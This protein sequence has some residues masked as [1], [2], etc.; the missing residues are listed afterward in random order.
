MLYNSLI[1]TYTGR[2]PA[3]QRRR[4]IDFIK[5]LSGQSNRFHFISKDNVPV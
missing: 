4:I 2:T 1:Y 3:G 5:V